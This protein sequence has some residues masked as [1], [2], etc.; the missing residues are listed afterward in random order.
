M[1]CLLLVSSQWILLLF[2][3][4]SFSLCCWV[5]SNRCLFRVS[6]E[7][8]LSFLHESRYVSDLIHVFTCFALYGWWKMVHRHQTMSQFNLSLLP[9]GWLVLWLT[10]LSDVGN[11]FYMTEV[12]WSCQGLGCC[13]DIGMFS[14]LIGVQG[15][16]EIRTT[17]LWNHV[18][19]LFPKRL[20]ASTCCHFK[21]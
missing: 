4:S 1:V 5:L 21:S 3:F 13:H 2:L 20:F 12:F 11:V 9:I 19:H 6:R 7:A 15:T 16:S 18:L 8:G 10:D 14:L 17:F